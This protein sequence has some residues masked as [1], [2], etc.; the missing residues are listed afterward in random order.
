MQNWS[1]VS[2]RADLS[3]DNDPLVEYQDEFGRTRMMRRS[4]LPREYAHEQHQ[5]ENIPADDE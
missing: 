1:G 4:E 5:D 2:S 3:Q